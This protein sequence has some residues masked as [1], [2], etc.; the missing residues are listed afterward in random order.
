[1]EATGW[2][3]QDE[4]GEARRWQLMS[5]RRL[6]LSAQA[7]GDSLWRGT[8]LVCVCVCRPLATGFSDGLPDLGRPSAEQGSA[9]PKDR[10]LVSSKGTR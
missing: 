7:S 3:S 2:T 6:G 1:M 10:P 9:L 4:R 8:G 5:D